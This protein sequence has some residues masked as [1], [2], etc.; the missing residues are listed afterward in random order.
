[1]CS[2]SLNTMLT[3]ACGLGHCTGAANRREVR[4]Q[5]LALVVV[6]RLRLGVAWACGCMPD[7]WLQV[8]AGCLAAVR[9]TAAGRHAPWTQRQQLTAP[10]L[11]AA[12]DCRASHAAFPAHS[13][14]WWC[15]GGGLRPVPQAWVSCRPG[16][17]QAEVQPE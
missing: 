14:C 11:L 5:W 17:P 2:R 12:C 4:Q 7:S 6:W 16:R 9:V 3:T 15:V 1:M 8:G 10:L 13:C